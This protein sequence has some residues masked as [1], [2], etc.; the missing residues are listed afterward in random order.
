MP[1][2]PN[3]PGL[4]LCVTRYLRLEHVCACGHCTRYVAQRAAVLSEWEEAGVDAQQLVGLHLAVG[5]IDQTLRQCAGQIAP[6]EDRRLDEIKHAAL[7]PVDETPWRENGQLLW[8]WVF[9]ALST[10]VYFMGPRRTGMFVNALQ[11]GF[12]GNLMSDGYLVYRIHANRLRCPAPLLRKALG[13]SE[14]TCHPHQRNRP[15]TSRSAR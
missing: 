12:Q 10:V 14:A 5:L 1:A 8:L 7:L 11:R 3:L 9:N 2:D 15:P 6:V 4:R 13:L